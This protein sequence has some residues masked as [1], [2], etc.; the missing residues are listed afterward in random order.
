MKTIINKLK[1]T[2]DSIGNKGIQKFESS[3]R[4]VASFLNKE[5]NK[6]SGLQ[7]RISFLT[8]GLLVAAMCTSLIVQSFDSRHTHILTRADKITLPND[9]Y[10]R[11]FNNHNDDLNTALRLNQFLD[12]LRATKGDSTMLDSLL[13]QRP[14]LMDSLD[15]FIHNYSN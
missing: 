8:L 14:G 10:K 5:V 2:A 15:L 13:R 3:Q 9:I 1:T 11:G 7:K 4:I 6:L 12:S